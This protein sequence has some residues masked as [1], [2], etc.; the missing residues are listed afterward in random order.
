M[1]KPHSVNK[2]NNFIGGWYLKDTLL[3]NQI[4]DFHKNSEEKSMGYSYDS[5]QYRINFDL[6]ES[7]DLSLE[8]NIE[9]REQYVKHLQCCINE[10]IKLY[11]ECAQSSWKIKENINIQHYNQGGGYKKWHCERNSINTSERHLVFM[12]YLTTHSDL[13]WWR[14]R[15]GTSFKYQKLNIKSE[16]GLTLIWPSDWTHTHKSNIC[17]NKEKYIVTGWLNYY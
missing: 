16:R 14:N 17:F 3:F 6:K 9:L 13:F 15:G 10:Y 12:T 5:N 7:I 4:I 11:P 1:L 8:K 2:K